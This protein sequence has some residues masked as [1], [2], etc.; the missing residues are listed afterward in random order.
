MPWIETHRLAQGQTPPYAQQIYNG[1]DC[2]LTHEV[3]GELH[4]LH[5]RPPEIYGFERAL[6][7]PALEMMLRGWLVDEGERQRGI[8][9]L[10]QKLRSLDST[11]QRFAWAVWG[12]G[13]NPRSND[14]LCR[15][16]YSTM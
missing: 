1:L 9:A 14:Q 15:F 3:W 5:K 7:A 16:F 13:L 6:Q 11:L 2:A 4:R 8:A 10:H 12:K